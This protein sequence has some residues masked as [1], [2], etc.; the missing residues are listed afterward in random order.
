M[1]IY[2]PMTNAVAFIVGDRKS[3]GLGWER[4]PIGTGFI[5]RV[6]SETTGI[7]YPYLVTCAHCTEVEWYARGFIEIWMRPTFGPV[8][9]LKFKTRDWRRPA[10]KSLD[11]VV[12][13]L[14]HLERFEGVIED[15]YDGGP[16]EDLPIPA[17]GVPLDGTGSVDD[18]WAEKLHLG[19][20]VHYIGLL[21]PM[22]EMSLRG[23]PMVRSGTLGRLYQDGLYF[24]KD[25]WKRPFEY[26]GHLIDCRSY[27]GFSGSPVFSELPL[28]RT[29][30]DKILLSHPV[31][32]LGMFTGQFK[33]RLPPGA[34]D[35]ELWARF[36]VGTV[37][38]VEYIREFIVKDKKM[39]KER[40]D[41]DEE[42]KRTRKS[43]FKGESSTKGRSAAYSREDFMRDLTK[44]TQPLEDDGDGDE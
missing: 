36:G 34:D 4:G 1:P 38:P 14:G 29:Q 17:A 7:H 3:E 12:T 20:I 5:V 35:D 25:E 6:Q 44:V 18:A 28:L 16:I 8:K 31:R 30:G 2:E 13:P 41:H 43:P 23:L 24:M 9:L 26:A 10:N 22:R 15:G 21:E 11:L 32:L 19:T 27:G 33:D 39:K 40:D 42:Y 37:L